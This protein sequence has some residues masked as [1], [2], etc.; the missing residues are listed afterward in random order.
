MINIQ[1][2]VYYR[3]VS[4]L[5]HSYLMPICFEKIEKEFELPLV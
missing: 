1:Q 3:N 4:I 2:D 5:F